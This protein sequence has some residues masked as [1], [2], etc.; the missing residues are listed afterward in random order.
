MISAVFSTFNSVAILSANSSLNP[1]FFALVIAAAIAKVILGVNSEVNSAVISSAVFSAV[2]AA[3][4]FEILLV[5]FF[6][7]YTLKLEVFPYE[8]ALI[9]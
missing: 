8:K 7:R 2:I 6:E 4:T 1:A 9:D 5:P 3:V